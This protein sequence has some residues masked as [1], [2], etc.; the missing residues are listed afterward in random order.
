MASLNV[1]GLRGHLDQV[2]ILMN[3]MGIDILALNE[4]KLDSSINQ[5]ITEIAGYNRQRLDRSRFGR[6]V[7]ILSIL[8]SIL[9]EEVFIR[10]TIKFHARNYI[11]NDNLEILCIEVHPRKSRP[12]LVV[13][14]YRPP[15]DPVSTFAKAEKFLSYLDKE[16]KEMILMGDTNCDLSSGS[17]DSNPRYIQNLY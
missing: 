13:A 15:S 4:T 3:D 12:I 5:N 6:G 11:P 10:D 17:P 1:N 14:W 8:V 7:S 16:G 2:K 9:L